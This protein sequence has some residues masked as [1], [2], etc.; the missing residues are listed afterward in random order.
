MW[1][2]QRE[3]ERRG[4][5]ICHFLRLYGNLDSR[6]I[7]LQC[8]SHLLQPLATIHVSGV[9]FFFFVL[10]LV[11]TTRIRKEKTRVYV[12]MEKSGNRFFFLRLRYHFFSQWV[13]PIRSQR[14]LERCGCFL[15]N[16]TVLA[17][18]S[19]ETVGSNDFSSL[20]WLQWW[21]FNDDAFA[22]SG[23]HIGL[24]FSVSLSL[25]QRSSVPSGPS[26]VLK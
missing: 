23:A 24:R 14:T 8:G 21:C 10:V 19:F 11:R 9:N 20:T 25:R 7:K 18:G 2:S 1:T 3:R 5:V 13:G 6:F 15:C 17:A 26:D 12:N 16:F 4:C 22:C